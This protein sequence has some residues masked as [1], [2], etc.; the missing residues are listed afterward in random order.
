M[1]HFMLLESGQEKMSKLSGSEP[2]VRNPL[3]IHALPEIQKKSIGS[4]PGN[5]RQN[6]QSEDPLRNE[7]HDR[8]E[9]LG[10]RT[11]EIPCGPVPFSPRSPMG[12]F[13][14][15]HRHASEKIK[16]SAIQ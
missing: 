14:L 3:N 13:H 1:F 8:E 10:T 9:K 6:K 16:F 2:C 12:G 7:G 15:T 5:K 11:I 4:R